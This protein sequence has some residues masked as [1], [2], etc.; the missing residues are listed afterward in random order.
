MQH[1]VL[2]EV[3]F[4]V[5]HSSAEMILAMEIDFPAVCADFFLPYKASL[6]SFQSNSLNPIFEHEKF[7]SKQRKNHF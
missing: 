2:L 1:H 5:I 7:I 3:F 4:S 6:K